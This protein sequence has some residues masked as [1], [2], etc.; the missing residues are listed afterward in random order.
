MAERLIRLRYAGLCAGCDAALS[1]GDQAWHDAST[2]TIRCQA[3]GPRH[4]GDV[5][6]GAPAGSSAAASALDG[7]AAGASA[8]AEGERRRSKRIERRREQF[9]AIGAALAKLND[10]QH[11]RAWRTGAVGERKTADRL[12]KHLRGTDVVL[13]HDRR[14]PGTRA[15]IDHLAVGPGGVTVIDSKHVEG[16]VNSERRGG[17]FSPRTEHLVIGGRDRTKFVDGVEQ[18]ITRVRQAVDGLVDVAGCICIVDVDGLPLLR[19][20]KVRDVAVVGARDAARLAARPGQLSK[21]EIDQ[22]A[23]TL[24]GKVPAHS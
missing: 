22:I 16:K 12:A 9:G 8:A 1:T 15:N 18:Q 24:A 14:I 2:R 5:L 21:S 20:I 11:E 10:P 19:R 23:H 6:D 3:C 7:G 4:T 13:L 17:L